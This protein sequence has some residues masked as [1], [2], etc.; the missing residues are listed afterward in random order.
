V[1]F[2]LGVT[3]LRRFKASDGSVLAGYLAYRLFLMLI[4]LVAILVAVAGFARSETAQAVEHLELGAAVA[5]SLRTAG[6][7]AERSRLPLLLS[8][9]FGFVVAAWGL[10]GGVQ[11]T[12]ARVW[13]I[14]T[15]RF[16][17]KGRAFVRLCG[18]LLLFAL[19]FYVSA[20]VRRLGVL[21]GLAGS[22]A[23]LTS[24]AVAFFGLGWILPRR[25]REWYWLLPGAAVGAAGAAGLQALA[26]F[27]LPDRLAGASATYG[28]FGVTLTVLSYMFLLGAIFVV[29]TVANAV[30]YER[31]R[32]DPPGVLRRLAGM[33]PRLELSVGSG[34]VP[35]GEAA[36]VVGRGGPD[37]G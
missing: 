22:L 7:D 5:D 23:G 13:Q 24:F 19:V 21:A 36:E 34:Y 9:L 20:V 16:P 29:S 4:P 15:S 3:F 10:L 28:A 11:I 6:E 14:P 17:S 25:C 37:P 27:Y 12:A 1:G 31:Y 18:S 26:T 30:I 35:E 8:G 32:E 33:V 2:D